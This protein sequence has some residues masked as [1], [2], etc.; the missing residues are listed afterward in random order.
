MELVVLGSGT[1]VPHPKR[2]AAGFWLETAAGS[3]LLDCSADAPHRMAQENLDWMNL[4]AIWISHLHLDHCAGLA[5]LL[6]GIKWTPGINRRQKPLRIFGCEGVT[7]LL[8]TIDESSNYKLFEQPF[9]LDCHEFAPTEEPR[10]VEILDGL[11][12]QI[13]ST[14]HRH[15]S[16]AI[17][18]TAADGTT[19][20]YSSDT[21]YAESVAEFAHGVDLLILE[22][23]F[24]RDKPTAKHLDLA[25]A[26]RIAKLAG[27]QKVLLTHLYPE[28][29]DVDLETEAKKLW[30]GETIAALTDCVSASGGSSIVKRSKAQVWGSI[31]IFSLAVGGLSAFGKLPQN[32]SAAPKPLFET[33]QATNLVSPPAN[34]SEVT[35]VSYNIRWRTGAELEQIASWLKTKHALIIALQEVDRARQRTGRTNNARALAESLGMYYAWAAPPADKKDQEEETG[36]ELLSAYPLTD[37]TP[38]VLPHK[39]PGRWRTAIGATI[40]LGST[41]IRVYSVHSETRMPLA[42]KLDQY[43]AAIEDLAR[44]PK[45]MP[46]IVMGDLNSWEPATGEALRKLFTRENFSTPFPDDETTFKRSAVVFDVELKLDWIWLRGVTA[47]S[48]GI[49]RSFTVSDHFPLWTEFSIV[50][51]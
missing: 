51:R 19:L 33:G 47:K 12:A 48:Y 5:P 9:P 30:A 13:I 15:E 29:D 28:W 49:D 38:I 17:R 10:P 22:C 8:K 39:G 50:T 25:D 21:G 42:Q 7:R 24:L 11:G 31:L 18:L 35:V 40:K 37:I 3:I 45:S 26:M 2:A 44:F 4:D 27:P 43:R 1:S 46:A 6:F 14:P 41:T 16:L 23:S 20:V 34:A 36:V 32:D